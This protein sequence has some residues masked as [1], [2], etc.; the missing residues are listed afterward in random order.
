[1]GERVHTL[2]GSAAIAILA[3]SAVAWYS[4]P[5]GRTPPI[6]A[7]P[8]PQLATLMGY[9]RPFDDTLG[10][11]PV[12]MPLV[13]LPRDPFGPAP[14]PA[15]TVRLAGK[16]PKPKSKVSEVFNWDVTATLIA[17]ARRAALINGV[18]VSVGD[19]VPGGGTLTAVEPDRVVLTDQKGSAHTVAVKEGDR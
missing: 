17:G 14:T 4:V 5:D 12:A 8:S 13:A 6:A 18:L 1:M 7:A 2:L 3:L 11:A 15:A 16:A 9:A 19:S 10:H